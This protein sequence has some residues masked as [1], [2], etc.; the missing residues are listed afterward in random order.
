MPALKRCAFGVSLVLACLVVAGCGPMLPGPGLGSSTETPTGT[1]FALP[2]GVTVTGDITGDM[3]G[4]HADETWGNGPGWVDVGFTLANGTT[5]DV[6]VEFPAGLIFIARDVTTQHGMTVQVIAVTLAKSTSRTYRLRLF[7]V[8]AHRS[9]A[10]SIDKFDFG[11]VTDSKGLVEIIGLLKGKT[12][13]D[14][15]GDTIQSAVWSVTDRG[16]LTAADRQAL[17]GL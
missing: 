8:N 5:A 13:D 2:G 3:F 1:P 14:S 6:T 4:D 16:G 15:S 17:R 12:L 9:V 7:C 10:T 11:P